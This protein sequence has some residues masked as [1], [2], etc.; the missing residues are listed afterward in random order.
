M[1][2][3]RRLSEKELEAIEILA[4]HPRALP[5]VEGK[6]FDT[7]MGRC[8][9]NRTTAWGLDEKGLAHA[10]WTDGGERVSLHPMT[11]Q[12]LERTARP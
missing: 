10:R 5:L 11:R 1:T 2:R 6:T 12:L 8:G 4:R 7:G 3:N 9:I